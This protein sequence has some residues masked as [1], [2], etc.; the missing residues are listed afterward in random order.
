MPPKN[1]K[2]MPVW[3]PDGANYHVDFDNG[4]YYWGG[5]VRTQADLLSILGDSELLGR[6]YDANNIGAD[7][8]SGTMAF[9]GSLRSDVLYGFTMRVQFETFLNFEMTEPT[10]STDIVFSHAP[11]VAPVVS[12]GISYSD[13][14]NPSVIGDGLAGD[15]MA[16]FTL[17]AASAYSSVDNARLANTEGDTSF[18]PHMPIAVT[19]VTLSSGLHIKN[20]TVWLTPKNEADTQALTV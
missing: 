4:Q 16:A 18:I 12:G 17:T 3:L 6:A 14:T 2:K 8:Y 5:Q 11:P 15:R 20:F 7:G 1:G 10:F 19:D 13:Q 9:I